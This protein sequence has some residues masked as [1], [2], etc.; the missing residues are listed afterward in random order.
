MNYYRKS[1]IIVGILFLTATLTGIISLIFVGPS[2]IAPDYLKVFNTNQTSIINGAMFELIMAFACAGIAIAA[3]PV[4]RKFSP[5]L[6]IGYVVFRAMEATL[7]V[8]NASGLLSLLKL[9]ESAVNSSIIDSNLYALADSILSGNNDLFVIGSGIVFPIAALMFYYIL[10]KFKLV[11]NFLSIWGLIGAICTLTGTILELYGAIA[12][13][14][15]SISYLAIPL[16]INELVLAFWLITK[17]FA[18]KAI[19]TIEQQ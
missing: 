8:V 7:F 9:S 2:M 17:G 4:L 10:Y 11:P 19:E 6:A 14:P 5:G 15:T 13:D 18:S 16:A 12:T 3:Y 1:S